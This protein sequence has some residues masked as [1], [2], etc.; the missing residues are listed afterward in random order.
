MDVATNK[1]KD[2]TKT[3]VKQTK[4]KQSMYKFSIRL[5]K[6]CRCLRGV[7]VR[8][9]HNVGASTTWLGRQWRQGLAERETSWKQSLARKWGTSVVAV[10][11]ILGKGV[12]LPLLQIA[13]EARGWSRVDTEGS[14][15]SVRVS[16]ECWLQT[17][18]STLET[19]GCG[20]AL[21]RKSCCGAVDIAMKL[22]ALEENE[23]C[24]NDRR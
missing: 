8:S 3:A 13:G 21:V 12:G 22:R 1:S 24:G 6:H 23:K 4:H 11:D 17:E 14:L 19:T 20:C 15:E 9:A 10:L 18:I 16:E 5:L 2:D 7:T